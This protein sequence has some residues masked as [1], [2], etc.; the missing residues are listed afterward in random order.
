MENKT[1]KYFKYA[2][3]E[4]ILVVIGIL[5]ALQINNW[6]EH[7]KQKEKERQV[8]TEIISDLDYTL[9]DL[10]RV[11]NTRTN[12]LNR[13]INSI[14]TIIDVLE[15]DNT[16]HDSLAYHFRAVNAYDEIDFKT[17]GYQS[18]VSIGTDLIEDPQLRSEIGKFHTSSINDTKGSFQEVHLDFYSYMLDYYRTYFTTVIVNDSI[19]KM[20]PNDFEGLK[21]D[22]E[23]Q[24]SLNAFLGVNIAYLETL[25]KV[26]IEA[27]K[28]KEAIENY[29][30]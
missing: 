1:G 18:L 23:Y 11:L 7:K 26:N 27:E 15:T 19:D 17:S 10:D 6:N 21:S 4:I 13:T 3:G 12:N 25:N 5:I 20:V 29:I 2:I 28:L 24:Q 9:F 22:R 16:Y 14:K 8:L 30:K